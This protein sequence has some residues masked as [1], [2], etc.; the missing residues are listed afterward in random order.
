MPIDPRWNALTAADWDTFA[1]AWL[2]ELRGDAND[3]SDMGQHVVM[4]NFTS[5]AEHQW[6]FITAAIRHAKT[7]D[8]LGHIAAGPVEHILGKHGDDYIDRVE[9]MSASN[10][11]F[12]KMMRSVWKHLM[13]DNV[14]GRVQAIQASANAENETNGRDS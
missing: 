14:W 12:K 10:P 2:A 9:E 6:S 3:D 1:R 11:Q 4:M 5:T 13:N 7:D 8:E